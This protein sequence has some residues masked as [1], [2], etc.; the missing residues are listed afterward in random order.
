MDGMRVLVDVR[1]G[2]VTIGRAT[3]GTSPL[4]TPARGPRP[5]LRPHAPLRRGRGARRRPA[6]LPR[7][8][9]AD[10]RRRPSRAAPVSPR[11]LPVTLMVFDLLRLFGSDLT[12]ATVGLASRAPRAPRPDRSPLRQCLRSTATAWSSSRRPPTRARGHHQQIRRRPPPTRR[13]APPPTGA[14]RHTATASRNVVGGWRPEGWARP[15]ASVPSSSDRPDGARRVAVRR[16]ASGRAGG[17]RGEALAR[18]SRRPTATPRRSPTRSLR[19]NATGKTDLGLGFR[20]VVIDVRALELTGQ[21]RLRQ[22]AYLGVRSDP[23]PA[24]LDEVDDA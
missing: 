13:A 8:H 6:E 23:S 14:R 19:S 16:S 7:P 21:H 10:A 24:D 2:A 5:R 1:D 11:P 4:P 9:R 3:S 22:P 20:A 12:W 15:G 18:R 17:H